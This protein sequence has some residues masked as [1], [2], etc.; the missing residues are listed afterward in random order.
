[1]SF[2]CILGCIDTLALW[3]FLAFAVIDGAGSWGKSIVQ[4][5]V[6][7]LAILINY[8]IN[9]LYKTLWDEIDPPKPEFDEKLT[10][11]EVKL[12]N[13][14]DENFDKWNTKY[15]S[16]GNTISNFTVYWSHKMFFM[17]FTHFFGQL[18]F[19]LRTQDYMA[20]WVWEDRECMRFTQKHNDY[21]EDILKGVKPH[22][23][24]QNNK[25]LFLYRGELLPAQKE[26][27]SKVML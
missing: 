16:I 18:H 5:A 20:R 25:N 9:F 12:I 10:L 23:K 19:T 3:T 27:Y 2:Y 6:P 14:C 1:M 4:M 8:G 21:T 17:P 22:R 15:E 26:P 24:N 13:K 11:E 7:G